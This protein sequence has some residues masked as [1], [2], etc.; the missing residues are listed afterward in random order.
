MFRINCRTATGAGRGNCLLVVVIHQV[1]A[2]ENAWQG[3]LGGGLFNYN[4]AVVIEF[5]LII[6]EGRARIMANCYEHGLSL[7]HI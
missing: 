2:G 6:E 1:T 3:G 5:D 7:I 4:I